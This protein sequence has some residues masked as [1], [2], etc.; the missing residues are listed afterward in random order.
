MRPRAGL[1]S[2]QWKFKALD[3]CREGRFDS[4]EYFVSRK[5]SEQL[6]R[7]FY[8]LEAKPCQVDRTPAP[9]RWLARGWDLVH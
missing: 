9:I 7:Q 6:K 1:G 5:N 8:L 4:E 3:T 2:D